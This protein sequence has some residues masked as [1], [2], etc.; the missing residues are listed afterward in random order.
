MNLHY[1][2][3]TDLT[4]YF[5]AIQ[6]E[7]L[8]K[9]AFQWRKNGG[10]YVIN[11]P[12]AFDIETS[13]FYE[14][15]EKRCL[16]YVWQFAFNGYVFIGRTWKQFTQFLNQLS[17]VLNV[18]MDNRLYIY[19]HN[20][21]YEFQFMRKWLEWENIF[22][23]AERK[24]L[25]ALTVEGYEFRDSYI[26]SGYN[27]A[28]TAEQLNQ[29][30]VKKLVGDLDYDLIRT[31]ITDLDETEIAY[32]VNDV[33]VV[34]AYI[35]EQINQYGKITKIPLTNTGR[36]RNYCREACYNGF[37]KNSKEKKATKYAYK[38]LMK[39]L[40]VTAD[41]YNLL[42][43]AFMGGFTHANAIHV[44]ETKKNV[45]SYDFTSSYPFVMLTELY[46]MGKGFKIKIDSLDKF[47]ELERNFC[48]V[49]D[50][51]LEGV[52]PKI[53]A[54]NPI[55]ISKCWK[56]SEDH[57]VNN[58]RVVTADWLITSGTEIDFEIYMKFY[59]IEHCYIDNC[60][61]YTKAYLPTNFLKSILKLYEDK[62]T[63]KGVEGKE[64]E[65]LHS[66]GMLN[67]CYGMCV[68]DIAQDETIY[69]GEWSKVKAS[70]DSL[71]DAIEKY[72]ENHNRFLFYPWGIY[73][74]AY[75]RRNLFSAIAECG[76]D[77]IYSDTDSVKIINAEKHK[78]YFD[79]YNKMVM[80]KIKR[81][82]LVNKLDE[83]QFKPKTIKGVEKPIGVWD[84]EG[85]YSLFKTLGA[86][87]YIYVDNGKLHATIAG[88][89]KQKA[90]SYL[91]RTYGTIEK[92]FENFDN[93]LCIPETDTGKLTHTYIDYEMS[94]TVT[95]YKGVKFDYY[96]KSGIHLEKTSFNMSMTKLFLDFVEGRKY[97]YKL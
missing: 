93:G 77:Y 45:T 8:P 41:E 64:V 27:L 1:E 59:D 92:V 50:M 74:T 96:E 28:K 68:T 37:T 44:L 35:Q 65:Y 56:I 26:L 7:E 18:S 51:R 15:G 16:M 13:S 5:N 55:S 73:V 63:L 71:N 21:S 23:T 20:L 24:P 30:S 53:W 46:P 11:V 43:R 34:S 38:K 75:A 49:F 58:G 54:D 36:V 39:S 25:K 72:N 42:K 29:Y 90:V 70:G 2:Y 83:N 66:K 4:E 62:T 88:T 80:L 69:D 91:M 79:V 19:V 82:C 9:R 94:G 87:R 40:T 78:K 86:K 47:R 81:S 6:K 89:G 3:Y 22:A 32:C 33:L 48:L 57:V 10:Y 14:N 97:E 85:T 52:A 67:S 84:C 95:D 76:A 12:C 17:I 60:Y 31:A 61:A